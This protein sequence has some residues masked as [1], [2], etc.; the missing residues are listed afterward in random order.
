M[1]K[2][3]LFIPD[4]KIQDIINQKV[5]PY[6]NYNLFITNDSISIPEIPLQITDIIITLPIINGGTGSLLVKW[7]GGIA[8]YE[9]SLFAKQILLGDVENEI[10]VYP[11][12]W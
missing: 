12:L 8:T 10:E 11:T 6:S 1:V 7:V 9:L 2:T 3:I 5:L 4:N